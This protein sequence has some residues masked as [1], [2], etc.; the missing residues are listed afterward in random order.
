MN[1]P[2]MVEFYGNFIAMMF[3]GGPSLCQFNHDPS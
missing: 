3:K 1:T 2:A